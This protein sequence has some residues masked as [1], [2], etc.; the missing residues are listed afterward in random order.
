MISAIRLKEIF[1]ESIQTK[2]STLEC[3]T[4]QIFKAG[5]LLVNTLQNGHKILACG[6]GG[7]AGDAQHFAS[8]LLNRF[9]T[10]R[11]SLPAIALSTDP[12]TMTAIAND[13]GYAHVFERQIHGLG[14][15]GD[16]L[17]AI[18]TSGRSLNIIKAVQAA[19]EKGM[20]VLAFNGKDGGP[21]SPILRPEDLELCVPSQSTARIQETHLLLIHCLCEIID[22]HFG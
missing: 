2:L 17:L 4:P 13:S 12:S 9:E 19:Q 8:E 6:N 7:S 14:Q 16:V 5:E 15:P 18:T 10:E 11:K 20:M 22:K 21:L 1:D 3:L